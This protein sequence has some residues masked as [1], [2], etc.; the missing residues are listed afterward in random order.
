MNLLCINHYH[1]LKVQLSAQK[2]IAFLFNGYYL[3]LA[4]PEFDLN[5]NYASKI[6]AI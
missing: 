5:I 1:L 3:S 2:P 4:F 6:L